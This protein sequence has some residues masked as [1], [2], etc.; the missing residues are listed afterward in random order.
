MTVLYFSTS[1]CGPCK[2]FKPVVQQV[3]QETGVQVQF[4]DAETSSL[5]QT[6]QITSVPTI[7][8]LDNTGNVAFRRTGVMGK[9]Q[10]MSTFSSFK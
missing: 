8:A 9:S 3:S 6:Y 1:W 10:L 7:V 2:M 4:I 5:A